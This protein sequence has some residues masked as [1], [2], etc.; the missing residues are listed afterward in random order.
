M[1]TS[2]G[3][4]TVCLSMLLTMACRGIFTVVTRA[5][6]PLSLTLVVSFTFLLFSLAAVSIVQFHLILKCVIPEAL[7][8]SVW[9]LALASGEY[10]LEPAVIGSAGHRGGFWQLLTEATPVAVLLPKPHHN[11][12]CTDTALIHSLTSCDYMPEQRCQHFLICVELLT[13]SWP[14]EFRD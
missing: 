1:S 4:R 6:S 2:T 13:L 12:I 14:W 7:P 9:G 3:W 10:F 8:L 5:H 11:S